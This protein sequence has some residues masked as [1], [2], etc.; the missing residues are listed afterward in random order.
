MI[1]LPAVLF[2]AIALLCIH[3]LP[4]FS[5]YKPKYLSC[6]INNPLSASR[7]FPNAAGFVTILPGRS[8][9]TYMCLQRT[10]VVC[11]SGGFLHNVLSKVAIDDVSTYLGIF[12]AMK[13]YISQMLC[14]M[15]F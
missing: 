12:A 11:L 6:Q 9:K 5:F 4:L 10:C 13:V 7:F 3:F 8:N 15:Y 14:E 1:L 2:K